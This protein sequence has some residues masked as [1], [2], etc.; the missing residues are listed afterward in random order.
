MSK[1][2]TI[3]VVAIVLLAAAQVG[4]QESPK[5]A[6]PLARVQVLEGVWQGDGEGFGQTS[7]VTH[8]WK[9]VL[10]G[11]F[12]RLKTRSVTEGADGA[13][14]VHE[15]VGYVS[16]S[17]GES[18]LRFRQFLSE[19]FVNTFRL[20]QVESPA[21]GF[22]F[23]PESTEGIANLVARMTL[24]F[25]PSGGYEMILELGAKGKPLKACQTMKLKKVK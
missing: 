1:Q 25:D 18:T 5:A 11:K 20:E 17:E 8:E 24:R 10:D 23:E 7:K 2:K 22:N 13:A 16:W 12:M 19:G 4:A 21:L 9:K 3:L 14:S 15:D 6:G